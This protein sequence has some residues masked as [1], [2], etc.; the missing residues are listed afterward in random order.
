MKVLTREGCIVERC[1]AEEAVEFCIEHL[2]DVSTVGVPSNQKMG[3]SKPLSSCT[4]SLVDRGLFNQ[5]YLYVLENT[6]EVLP[7]IEEH[8]IHIKI[9]YP[10]FRKRT[11]WLQVCEWHVRKEKGRFGGE[12]DAPSPLHSGFPN[13]TQ[14]R[15]VEDSVRPDFMSEFVYGY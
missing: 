3:L 4:V 6:E 12:E 5:A 13:R 10:K 1:I 8:M 11:K 14:H 2:S 9:T 7:Y 15:E